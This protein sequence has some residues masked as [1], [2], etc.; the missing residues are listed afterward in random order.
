MEEYTIT[1]E[2]GLTIVER[3]HN[4]FKMSVKKNRKPLQEAN[5]ALLEATLYIEDGVFVK[6]S[7][8]LFEAIDNQNLP[9]SADVNIDHFK[10]AVDYFFTNVLKTEYYLQTIPR[11]STL[12]TKELK[13]FLFE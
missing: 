8:Y 10:A 7:S 3:L 5:S 2:N 1:V 6:D 12:C 9:I 11:C 4:P 13:L